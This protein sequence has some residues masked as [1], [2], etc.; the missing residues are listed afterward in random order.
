MTI[1]HYFSLSLPQSKKMSDPGRRQT[2]DCGLSLIELL[3]V[4]VIIAIMSALA[5]NP[6]LS[7]SDMKSILEIS[8]GNLS[9]HAR[10]LEEAGYIVCDKTFENRVPK[11]TY[12]LTSRGRTAL[13]KYLGHLEA[14]IRAV[15][16]KQ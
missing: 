5:V 1:E 7:F 16:K 11:T 3:L 12:K 6:S 8:D 14:V 4:I 9:V 10:K 13:E 15:K 2:L